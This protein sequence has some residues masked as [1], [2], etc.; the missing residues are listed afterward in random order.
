MS[1]ARCVNKY[2]AAEDVDYI[3]IKHIEVTA[4]VY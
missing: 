2:I 4:A 3:C 1:L